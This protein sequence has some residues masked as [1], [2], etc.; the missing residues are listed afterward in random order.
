MIYQSE[1]EQS[2]FAAGGNSQQAPAQRITDFLEGKLSATLP[3]TSYKPGMTSALLSEVLPKGL[4]TRLRDGIKQ[5]GKAM[6][7]YIQDE[8]VMLGVET[9]TS[10]PVRIPRDVESLQHLQIDGFYPCGEGAGYAGG[11]VSAAMDGIRVA[12]SIQLSF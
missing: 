11:I 3:E 5:F 12:D 7:G 9:R 10:S 4:A 1:V 6:N 2:A 8:A